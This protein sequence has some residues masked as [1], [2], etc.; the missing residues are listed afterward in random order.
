MLAN[1]PNTAKQALSSAWDNLWAHVGQT[2]ATDLIA[3]AMRNAAGN[4]TGVGSFLG[5]VHDKGALSALKGVI[6]DHPQIVGLEPGKM[7]GSAL[8]DWAKEN[9]KIGGSEMEN[10]AANSLYRAGYGYQPEKQL[11]Q[12]QD[13]LKI[14]GGAYAGPVQPPAVSATLNGTA[15]VKVGNVTVSV[16]GQSI[17]AAIAGEIKG[18]ISGLFKGAAA[19]VK[20]STGHDGRE[21]P[22]YPDMWGAGHH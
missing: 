3:Q 20:E 5:D 22:T 21:S 11:A 19:T 8:L 2:G 4:L 13:L 1:N 18:M 7:T 6:L 12:E 14:R 15:E 9:I 17:A 16:S 10:K